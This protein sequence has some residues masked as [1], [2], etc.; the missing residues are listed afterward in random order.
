M[1]SI[2]RPIPYAPTPVRWL[3]DGWILAAGIYLL[4]GS[5]A[6][7]FGWNQLRVDATAYW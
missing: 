6:S 3:R 4:A 5:F 7:F 1:L 2:S